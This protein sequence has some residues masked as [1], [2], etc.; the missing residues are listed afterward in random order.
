MRELLELVGLEDQAQRYPHQ[1]SGGQQQRVALIRAMAPRPEILL[2]DE[3]FSSMDAELRSALALEVRRILKSEGATAI[4]VTHDQLE[5]FAMADC[6]G[7]LGDGRMHQCASPY[8]LYHR[9]AD[10]FVASFIGR[11][12]IL[13]GTVLDARRVETALGVFEGVVTRDIEPGSPVDL[14]VRPDDVIHDDASE[15]KL[16][17]VSKTF[18]GAEHLYTLRVPDG[19]DIYCLVPSHHNHAVGERI[20]VQLDAQHLVPFRR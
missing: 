20:G 6:I 7:V 2:L 14:L 4:L 1:L 11:S 12:A 18:R 15:L 3:P 9:P 13:A 8:D 16:E 19:G 17:V 5:A 10:R